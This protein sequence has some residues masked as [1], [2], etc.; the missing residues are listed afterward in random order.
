MSMKDIQVN[1]THIT[2]VRFGQGTTIPNHILESCVD[3]A[4]S[5]TSDIVVEF[6]SSF[7][8]P[9][10]LVQYHYDYD[11]EEEGVDR[12]VYDVTE[13]GPVAGLAIYF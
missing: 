5:C 12:F 13:Q 2:W 11:N 10:K 8:D 9:N 6:K 7:A 4:D 1:I 3:F